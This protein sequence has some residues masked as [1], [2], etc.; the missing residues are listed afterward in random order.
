MSPIHLLIYHHNAWPRPDPRNNPSQTTLSGLLRR[1]AIDPARFTRSIIRSN[2]RAH[3]EDQSPVPPFKF[4]SQHNSGGI[5]V[6]PFLQ[7][8]LDEIA[9]PPSNSPASSSSP[10]QHPQRK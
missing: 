7:A 6:D 4:N 5:D 10:D 1:R 3:T 9:P 2:M 8:D